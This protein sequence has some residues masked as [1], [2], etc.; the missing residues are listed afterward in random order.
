MTAFARQL[1]G[2][3]DIQS[4]PGGGTAITLYMPGKDKAPA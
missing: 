3:L 2:R 4:K 1:K